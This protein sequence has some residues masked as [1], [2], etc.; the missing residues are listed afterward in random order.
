MRALVA[1]LQ[2]IP[3]RPRASVLRS[4]RRELANLLARY[5][6]EFAELTFEGADG[7]RIG[8]SVALHERP[9]PG[10]VIVHGTFSTRRFDYVR[11]IAIRAHR[12][13]GFNVAA[14]DLRGFGPRA[15]AGLVN[16]GGWKEAADVI[17][18]AG[19][20]RARGAT[21]V[22][23]LGISLGGSATLNAG[24]AD[25][26]QRALDGGVAAVSPAA[27]VRSAAALISRRVDPRHPSY[28]IAA[29]V[30]RLRGG[31]GARWPSGVETLDRY[32]ELVAARRYE[33]APE[34]LYTR[35]SPVARIANARVP[36]LILHPEG[37]P[38]VKVENARMLAQA[39]GGNDLVHVWLLGG[40][41]HGALDA[42]DP[43]WAYAVYRTFFERWADY[44]SRGAA[45]MVYSADITER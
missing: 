12:D 23:A 35:A 27:E 31:G 1:E 39:S 2:R 38:V 22:G 29:A 45:E 10:L 8:A 11:Q 9:R 16:T 19:L 3:S 26:A 25:G 18:A 15:P 17:A 37:D 4:L 40:A 28:P 14:I 24:C 42:E 5:P 30:A 13:W 20:L 36:T 21:S 33:I 7:D 43:D 44:P 32:L 41:A 34:E 6:S